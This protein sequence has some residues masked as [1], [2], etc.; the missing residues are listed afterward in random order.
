MKIIKV[1]ACLGVL[2][3][4]SGCTVGL[5]H[6]NRVTE[7]RTIKHIHVEDNVDG[8]F[9]YKNLAVSVL[10]GKN[11]V[12]LDIPPEGIAF[13]GEKNIYILT[14]GT[15]ELLSLDKIS[16]QVPLVSG[17]D[18]FDGLMLRLSS[19]KKNEELIHFSQTLQL[20]VNKPYG[21]ISDSELHTLTAAG[22]W[23]NGGRYV[24]Q[25]Q[26]TGVI[27]PIGKNSNIFSKMK[28][29]DKKHKIQFYSEDNST[30]F[31][32]LRLATNVALTP[33]TAVADIVFFPI[34][35]RLLGLFSNPPS[36]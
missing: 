25:V 34:S 4:L 30:K 28:S 32:P 10:Q 8:V 12:A 16:T 36:R 7:K 9:Q 22:F 33:V 21:H 31:Y 19:P 3:L 1:I 6:D 23:S 11:H 35:L 27:I 15:E 5:W 26:I 17:F 2:L 29:L 20:R 18:K 13:L 14:Q 24:K